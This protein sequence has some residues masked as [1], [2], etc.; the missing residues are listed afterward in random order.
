MQK[1]NSQQ[2][3]MFS[4]VEFKEKCCN[5]PTN[6]VE[7]TENLETGRLPGWL[8]LIKLGKRGKLKKEQNAYMKNDLILQDLNIIFVDNP[9]VSEALSEPFYHIWKEAMKTEYNFLVNEIV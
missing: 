7:Q 1:L 8:K 5:P 9:A 3:K 4:D 6:E 2:C